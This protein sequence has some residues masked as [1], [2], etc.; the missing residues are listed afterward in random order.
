MPLED[1]ERVKALD[2]Q[3]AS[4]I[5]GIQVRVNPGLSSPYLLILGG[6]GVSGLAGVHYFWR[7]GGEHPL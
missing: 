4:G 1:K 2:A 7:V 6:G 5:Q 3:P